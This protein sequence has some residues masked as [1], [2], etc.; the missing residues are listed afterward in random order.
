MTSVK[1]LFMNSSETFEGWSKIISDGKPCR[2][3][4]IGHEKN[5]NDDGLIMDN[6]IETKM[7]EILH[8]NKIDQSKYVIECVHT[9]Y[10]YCFEL[11][12]YED[13]YRDLIDSLKEKSNEKNIINL[14][15]VARF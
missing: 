11:V 9:Y 14:K 5:C 13:A 4:R 6:S 1:R 3:I 12:I 8:D 10:S 15:E 2:V 7:R